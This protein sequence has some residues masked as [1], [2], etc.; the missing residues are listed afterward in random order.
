[1]QAKRRETSR[2]GNHQEKGIIK[3]RESSK[4]TVKLDI[5]T[6]SE[7][8]SIAKDKFIRIMEIQ[9]LVRIGLHS[10]RTQEEKRQTTK[11]NLKLKKKLEGHKVP[12]SRFADRCNAPSGRNTWRNKEDKTKITRIFDESTS[13][14]S[15]L[16]FPCVPLRF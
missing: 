2:E 11:P 6:S 15:E 3:R 16:E 13:A 10:P 14:D 4:E 5:Q 12:P 1:M 8:E 9:S 7:A